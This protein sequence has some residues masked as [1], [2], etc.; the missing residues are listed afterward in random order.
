MDKK[1]HIL[2]EI[3]RTAE[4]DGGKPLGK[5]RFYKATG[6]KM[7]D[8]YGKP[9]NDWN[10]FGDAQK[11]AGYTPNKFQKALDKE[12]II[13][14]L[15]TLIRKL[16]HFPLEAE[17]RR[18]AAKN[19]DFPSHTVFGSRLGNKRQM[20][21]E[22]V[23]FCNQKPDEYQDVLKICEPLIEKIGSNNSDV[24]DFK[25]DEDFGYVY[26]MKSGKYYKIGKTNNIDRRQ[27]EVGVQLPEKI[28][29][30]KKKKK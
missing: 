1:Q 10:S 12:Y 8:W 26:L 13:Q 30:I 3:K 24:D 25:E 16:D 29:P 18:E 5:Q 4:N 20:V 7:S 9:W 6:I 27:Y 14:S 2:N 19:K 21:N 28:K 11:E 22:I 17:R 23:S 15:I